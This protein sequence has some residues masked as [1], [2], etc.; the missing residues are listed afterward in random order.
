MLK[1][2]L[3]IVGGSWIVIG[4]FFFIR[5]LMTPLDG[6]SGEMHFAEAL[7]PTFLM[8]F[9]PGLVLCGIA[10]LIARKHPKSENT[11]AVQTPPSR[12]R[13]YCNNC[14]TLLGLDAKFCENCG[15]PKIARQAGRA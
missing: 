6:F 8:F 2:L 15:A 1:M 11:P 3:R 9:L 4:V 14:G 5:C 10:E 12:P 7:I 13:C